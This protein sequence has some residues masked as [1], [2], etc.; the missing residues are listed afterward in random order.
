MDIHGAAD[1][2]NQWK[3]LV[4][5]YPV[6]DF[7]NMSEEDRTV[8]ICLETYDGK[9]RNYRGSATF[10][11]FAN[12]ASYRFLLSVYRVQDVKQGDG[13]VVEQLGDNVETFE[14]R[15]TSR[16]TWT[17]EANK[18]KG[19]KTKGRWITLLFNRDEEARTPDG[20]KQ[21]DLIVPK[22]KTS[23]NGK[24]LELAVKSAKLVVEATIATNEFEAAR[25]AAALPQ[26]T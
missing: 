19:S 22:S 25:A 15:L 18:V 14:L 23:D 13:L 6:D 9:L 26:Q 4:W 5:L 1:N 3:T 12:S 2:T 20:I 21:I 8:A 24:L 16:F 11:R 10:D 7:D 17:L